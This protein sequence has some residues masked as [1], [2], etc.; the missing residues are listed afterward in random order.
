[1]ERNFEVFEFGQPFKI[2]HLAIVPYKVDHSLSGQ[3]AT[4]SILLLE[5][6]FTLGTF[7]FHGCIDKETLA[8]MQACKETKPDVLIIEGTRIDEG[9][10]KKEKDVEDEICNFSG[11]A[12]ELALC[13]WSIRE[14]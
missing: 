1:M 4:L 9:T 12:N 6:L 10:S 13:N 11:K 14:H 7:I 2:K 8:F 5:Q 3:Q